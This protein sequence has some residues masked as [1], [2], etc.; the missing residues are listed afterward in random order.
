MKKGYKRPPF[1]KEWRE[2]ISK[3]LKGRSPV[4]K[5]K[6]MSEEQRKKISYAHTGKFGS[7]SGAWKGGITPQNIHIQHSKEGR[8]WRK[9]VFIR[10]NF[11]CQKYEIRGRNLIAHHIQNFSDFPELRFAIDNGITLS[12]KAHDEFHKI[13]GKQNNTKEQL[14]EFLMDE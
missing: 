6:K 7:L 11:T 5:G 8:L 3:T 14:E 2:K 1:S 4:N 13:Y 9:S 12:R 10:D